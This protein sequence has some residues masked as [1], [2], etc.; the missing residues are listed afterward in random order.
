[1]FLAARNDGLL[2]SLLTACVSRFSTARCCWVSGLH[3]NGLVRE[4]P[5]YGSPSVASGIYCG[6]RGRW[7]FE[8][9]GKTGRTCLSPAAVLRVSGQ[10]RGD[11]NYHPNRQY[12]E[13]GL[14]ED[15]VTS[16]LVV[17]LCSLLSNIILDIQ[18]GGDYPQ[19]RSPASGYRKS[20]C[21]SK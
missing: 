12:L 1:M 2:H 15:C 3:W 4:V 10:T 18:G 16:D 21:S 11:S 8:E 14:I 19:R 20:A 5:R 17:C 6:L 9:G 7:K 13:I